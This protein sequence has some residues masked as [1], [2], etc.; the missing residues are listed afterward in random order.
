[1]RKLAGTRAGRPVTIAFDTELMMQDGIRLFTSDEAFMSADW[2][3]NAYIIYAFHTRKNEFLYFNRAYPELRK[4][5]REALTTE[6]APGPQD[7]NPNF[8]RSENTLT[9]EKA[10]RHWRTVVEGTKSGKLLPGSVTEI[11]TIDELAPRKGKSNDRPAGP[12]YQVAPA[13]LRRVPE[14]S[15]GEK[16]YGRGWNNLQNRYQSEPRWEDLLFTTMMKIP[17]VKCWNRRCNNQQI[18]G[19]LLCQ[20]CRSDMVAWTDA[21]IATEVVRLEH[22]A[23]LQGM[24]L[25]LEDLQGGGGKWIRS[26]HH[27]K[28]GDKRGGISVEASF[29]KMAK[30][31]LSKALGMGCEKVS[32][33]L[34]VDPFYAYNCATQG[35][36]PESLDFLGRIARAV[37]ADPGRTREERE[38]GGSQNTGTKLVFIPSL[39]KRDPHELNVSTEAF[40]AHHARFYSIMQFAV[41]CAYRFIPGKQVPIIIGHSGSYV[42]EGNVERILEVMT[43]FIR[44]SWIKFDSQGTI[45]TGELE[46]PQ[47]SSG[48]TR[49]YPVEARN[50]QWR[51]ITRSY[52]KGKGK[53][54]GKNTGRQDWSSWYGWSSGWS[55]WRQGPWG[56]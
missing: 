54:K 16:G 24:V 46:I 38:R 35:L 5:Y 56:W 2:V 49:T 42:P 9:A 7:V 13:T 40:I 27:F 22:T 23:S 3:G 55:Q 34:S 21:R 17:V 12:T 25:Y 48:R 6:L 19:Y 41:M 15:R 36:T 11:E 33:R 4:R 32:D 8:F 43:S 30:T 10:W 26:K 44:A 51:A 47:F 52:T 37:V 28:E 14:L 39:N 50:T 53:G 31:H 20:E 45:C 18:D 29:R 1:M